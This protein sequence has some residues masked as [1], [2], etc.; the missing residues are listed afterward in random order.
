M[1]IEMG[2]SLFY[3]WL[4]H[5]KE[6]QIVQT[7]WKV[8]SQW[9]MDYESEIKDLIEKVDAH[10]SENYDY[11]I[12]KK[13]SSMSQIIQ[14]GECDVVGV[15]F[16]GDEKSF[17]AVDV[18]FHEAGLNYGTREETVMKVISKCVRNAVCLYGYMNMKEAEIIFAS[19]KINP[20][21]MG[22]LIPCIK[23]LN[24]LLQLSGFRFN[25]R[26]IANDE[27]KKLVLQPILLASA[28]IADTSELFIRSYQMYKMFAGDTRVKVER[29][30]GKDSA[31]LNKVTSVKREMYDELKIG[32]LVQLVLKP[33]IIEKATDLEIEWMQEFEYSKNNFG[34][35]YPLL[36]KTKSS[37]A[38]RHYYK[39]MFAINGDTYRL[40]CEWFETDVNNDRPYVEKWIREHE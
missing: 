39:D 35:Q 37:S 21:I 12:F 3:S 28:G 19:P 36:L 5:V 30:E 13:N 18:A 4:R 14:Q 33:L 10:F 34:I 32:K 27:F 31:P 9:D 16:N 24:Y 38:E 6:C 20:A 8:S 22:D 15:A 40:C 25:I 17:Y 7:N 29:K 1:K 11:H 26:V 23:E 2:E